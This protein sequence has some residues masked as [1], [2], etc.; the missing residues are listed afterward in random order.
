[1]KLSRVGQAPDSASTDGDHLYAPFSAYWGAF[2]GRNMATDSGGLLR[3]LVDCYEILGNVL[4]VI[5]VLS[6]CPKS[7]V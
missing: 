4:L 1:M 7:S 2:S 3:R 5:F 6:Q